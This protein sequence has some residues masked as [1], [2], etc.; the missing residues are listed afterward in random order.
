M[1]V[2]TPPLFS[3]LFPSF[4]FLFSSFFLCSVT[5]AVEWLQWQAPEWQAVIPLTFPKTLR[6]RSLSWSSGKMLR[7]VWIL[8][9]FCLLFFSNS[10]R[11]FFSLFKFCLCFHPLLCFFFVW[12]LVCSFLLCRQSGHWHLHL[13]LDCSKEWCTLTAKVRVAYVGCVCD[14]NSVIVYVIPIGVF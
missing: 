9:F 2:L 12:L 4:S 10:L 1:Y 5:N 11:L 13:F 3:F 8:L 7:Q 6:T 14:T